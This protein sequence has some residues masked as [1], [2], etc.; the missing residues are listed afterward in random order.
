MTNRYR[1]C[2]RCAMDTSDPAIS[3]DGEGFCN[4][5]RNFES[6][7]RKH[8][9][10]NDEGA[11]QL[12]AIVQR[13]KDDGAGRE[14]DCIIGLSGGVDSS[15]LALKVAEWGLRPLVV[16]VDAGWNSELA[17][18]NIEKIVKHCKFDLHTHVVDWEE[19]RDLH[20]AYLRSGLSNQDVPQDHVFFASL[21]HFATQNGIRYILSGG[22]IATESIFP[23]AWHGG[24][25]MDSINLKAVHRQYG[26]R[27]LRSYNTISFFQYY[28]WYPFVKKMR[29]VRPLNY[30]PYD[31]NRAIAE[32]EATIGWRS[33]GRKHGESLFTKVFQNDFLPRK[34]GYDK[35]RPHLSSLVVSGQM[36]RDVAL[37]KL[38]EP[39][40]DKD[41]LEVDLNYFCKK[42]RITRE[43]YEAFIQGP[44]REYAS[45]PNWVSRHRALKAVQGRVERLLG[46]R[47]NVY[48]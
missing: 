24:S 2:S 39:L 32:L 38:E 35:R 48:S 43:Q 16:H 9:F 22:N 3:F 36:S 27:P 41:E 10:P 25:A 47:I 4:H 18:A 11:R 20:L 46:R 44:K 7:T 30:M 40:Y 19:M 31:K 33:Y 12:A 1:V 28:V 15:Y 14:Y 17:V 34:F 42:L 23:M 6:S 21:Y 26:E 37:A 5:C 8:W 13:I 45:F 29:T